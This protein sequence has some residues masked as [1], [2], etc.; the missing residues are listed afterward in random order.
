[1]NAD[2]RLSDS[3][4]QKIS[5]VMPI[6]NY[7]H[8]NPSLEY[9]DKLILPESI[10][11]QISRSHLPLPPVFSISYLKNPSISIIC[12]VLNFKAPENTLYCPL[13][14]L[15]K[16]NKNTK[17]SNSEI[18]VEIL[19]PPRKYNYF[20]PPVQ[21]I[22]VQLSQKLP[23]DQCKIGLMKYTVINK[24]EYI[25]ILVGNRVHNVFIAGVFPKNKGIIKSNNFEIVML[26]NSSLKNEPDKEASLIPIIEV[27]KTP[28]KNSK[29]HLGSARSLSLAVSH[30]VPTRHNSILHINVELLP[31][32]KHDTTYKDLPSLPEVQTSDHT[33][34]LRPPIVFNMPLP[35]LKTYDRRPLSS[36]HADFYYKAVQTPLSQHKY[37]ISNNSS[38]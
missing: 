6:S 28:N 23:K 34:Q 14:I 21:K 35:Q 17:T 10:L 19:Q 5:Y 7:E 2:K 18:I 22:S 20:Y 12:G 16:L 9:S 27:L 8:F 33:S 15:K 30:Q 3:Y 32:E 25:N 13:W 29:G 11:H 24:G 36:L 4:Y 38:S 26:P 37:T 1:M 31:W